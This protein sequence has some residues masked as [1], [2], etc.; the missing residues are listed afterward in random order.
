MMPQGGYLGGIANGNPETPKASDLG[1]A[2]LA[3][4]PGAMSVSALQPSDSS[5]KFVLPAGMAGGR[6]RRRF[7]WRTKQ[8]LMLD[9]P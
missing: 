3:P 9:A 1:S 7:R 6:V 4:S 2:A 5:L 8:V